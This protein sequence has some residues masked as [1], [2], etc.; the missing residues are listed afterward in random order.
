MF[1]GIEAASKRVSARSR[2]ILIVLVAAAALNTGATANALALGGVV[3]LLTHPVQDHF[4][5]SGGAYLGGE[6]LRP[7]MGRIG[8]YQFVGGLHHYEWAR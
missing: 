5:R 7:R 8:R 3:H 2:K 4:E 6:V 1:Q